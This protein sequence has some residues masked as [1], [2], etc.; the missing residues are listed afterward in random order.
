[1]SNPFAQVGSPKT[2]CPG[3]CPD[4]SVSQ[5]HPRTYSTLRHQNSMMMP[6]DLSSRCKLFSSNGCFSFSHGS[7]SRNC[8]TWGWLIKPVIMRRL[9]AEHNSNYRKQEE[10]SSERMFFGVFYCNLSR[11]LRYEESAILSEVTRSFRA[12]ANPYF[13]VLTHNP[14][15]GQPEV[16][17]RTRGRKRAVSRLWF[18]SP[19]YQIVTSQ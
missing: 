6:S 8:S 16:S 4:G 18:V 17:G 14:G 2:G 11:L 10:G 13:F 15:E 12:I 5:K 3:L 7:S 1:M 19:S 9:R